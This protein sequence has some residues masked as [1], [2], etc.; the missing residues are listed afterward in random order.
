MNEKQELCYIYT[1]SCTVMAQMWLCAI[2]VSVY[3]SVHARPPGLQGPLES[4]VSATPTDFLLVVI[5]L[6]K[7][8]RLGKVKG[9]VLVS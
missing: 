1:V 3:G 5:S 2:G 9:I 4:I 6:G 8:V 7:V